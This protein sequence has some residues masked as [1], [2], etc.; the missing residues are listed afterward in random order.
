[1]LSFLMMNV[2]IVK[3]FNAF[4]IIHS[5]LFIG[6]LYSFLDASTTSLNVSNSSD[7]L[8]IFKPFARRMNSTPEIYSDADNEIIIIIRFISP[9]HIRKIMIIG[10]GE[11]LHHPSLLKCYVNQEQLDFS[12]VNNIRSVQEFSLPINDLG[13]AELITGIHSF[14]NVTNLTLYFSENHGNIDMTIIRYIGL[15]GEHTHY[16]REAVNTVY[17]V[18]C[19]GQ[20]IHQD[21]SRSV[22]NIDDIHLH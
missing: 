18:L 6:N 4:S 16:R 9:V 15:Q 1:M 2:C 14:R 20:D 17:E 10:G 22:G 12:S 3:D 8:G 5:F 13:N 7:T 19:N 11:T 21:E